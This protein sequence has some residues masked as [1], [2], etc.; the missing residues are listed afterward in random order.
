MRRAE[1]HAHQTQRAVQG[2][3]AAAKQALSHVDASA[4]KALGVSGQQHGLVALDSG[5]NVLRPAKLWCDT[6]SAPEAAELSQLLGY[7]VVR[8]RRACA[9]ACGSNRCHRRC[10]QAQLHT[11][12]KRCC[13]QSS[14]RATEVAM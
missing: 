1:P 2:T 11:C 9:A 6:E 7:A 3:L 10:M 5:G 8:R 14:T 13:T 12:S 4:V